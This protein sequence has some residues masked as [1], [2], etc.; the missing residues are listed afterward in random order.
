[1]RTLLGIVASALLLGSSSAAFAPRQAAPTNCVALGSPK[2]AVLFSYRYADT[3]GATEYTNQWKQFSATGSEL[4]T[5]HQRDERVGPRHVYVQD[6]S[7]H[8]DH[9]E[10]Q[11]AGDRARR[12]VHDGALYQDDELGAGPGV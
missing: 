5:S 1:M 9:R 7:R 4:V 11:R 8:H 10:H 3:T 6:R 2:P 12:D